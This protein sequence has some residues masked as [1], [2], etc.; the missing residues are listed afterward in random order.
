MGLSTKADDWQCLCMAQ[1]GGAAGVG[2]GGFTFDWYRAQAAI[3]GRFLLAVAGLGLG[4]NLGGTALG[5][6]P[7]W[8]AIDCDRPFSL[9]DLHK[10]DGWIESVGIGVGVTFSLTRISARPIGESR[11]LFEDENISGLGT[12]AGAGLYAL[13]G[14]WRFAR[15][16]RNRPPAYADWA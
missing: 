15:V 16:V 12:G 10:S 2:A 14:T 3:S 13:M 9:N 6:S 11:F 7:S 5:E 8:S 1:V 4:G